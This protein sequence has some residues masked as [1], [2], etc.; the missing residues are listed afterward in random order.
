MDVPGRFICRSC[1]RR[2]LGPRQQSSRVLQRRWV[3]EKYL[4]KQQEAEEQWQ[5]NAQLIHRG[6]KQSMLSMLEE[7]GYVDTI[8]G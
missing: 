3:S 4:K 8:A 7:R 6:Q 2:A 5:A 1:I